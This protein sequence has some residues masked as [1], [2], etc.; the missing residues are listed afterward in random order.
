MWSSSPHRKK[1]LKEANIDV[2]S[3]DADVTKLSW[4]VC[5]YFYR[6]HTGLF[7]SVLTKVLTLFFPIQVS[8]SS[9]LLQQIMRQVMN[10]YIVI[11]LDYNGTGSPISDDPDHAFMSNKVNETFICK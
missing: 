5:Q 4:M 6:M 8:I 7:I 2:S 9:Q 1:I 3:N 11:F 10:K